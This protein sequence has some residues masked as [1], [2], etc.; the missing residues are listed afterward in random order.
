MFSEEVAERTRQVV[1]EGEAEEGRQGA[2]LREATQQRD[3]DAE[4]GGGV[5][6]ED[7]AKDLKPLAVEVVV[8]LEA[9]EDAVVAH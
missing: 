2:A 7:A 6:E 1:E 9:A 5:G 8:G 3:L 4:D